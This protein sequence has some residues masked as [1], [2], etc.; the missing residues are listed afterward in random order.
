MWEQK[1]GC[2]PGTPY[3]C[4]KVGA[5]T[6]KLLDIAVDDYFYIYTKE[7]KTYTL[8]AGVRTANRQTHTAQ[9]RR[10]VRERLSAGQGVQ[11]QLLRGVL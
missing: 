8:K 10:A 6:A 5:R 9:Q 11:V 7:R 4:L 2:K 3:Y 1:D